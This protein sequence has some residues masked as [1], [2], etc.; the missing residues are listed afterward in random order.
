M[1]ATFVLEVLLFRNMMDVFVTS[2]SSSP[3]ALGDITSGSLVIK[4]DSKASPY[5][6]LP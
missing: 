4:L 5:L 1:Y 2:W 3:I 6:A